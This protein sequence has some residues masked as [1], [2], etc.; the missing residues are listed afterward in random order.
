MGD[1]ISSTHM[2]TTP[3]RKSMP[4]KPPV[5]RAFSGMVGLPPEPEDLQ[6]PVPSTSQDSQEV[7]TTA[8]IVDEVFARVKLTYSKREA[9]TALQIALSETRA[10]PKRGRKP[11][12]ATE[13]ERKA[14]D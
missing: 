3:V 12:Y 11:K 5:K 4:R 2:T 14:A 10:L 9:R 6:K 7:R 8:E 1:R 13:E